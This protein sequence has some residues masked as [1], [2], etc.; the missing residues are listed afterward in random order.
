[1]NVRK[2]LECLSPRP[3]L[4]FVSKYRASPREAPFKYST[5]GWAAG[6]THIH[7]TK[8]ERPARD[9]HSSLLQNLSNYG[10]K[11]FYNNM[12]RMLQNIHQRLV[13]RLATARP[14]VQ[15]F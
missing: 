14:R 7:L 10:R 5:L 13:K 12:S 11:K 4:M 15:G 3:S 2:K 1:M 9:K 8:L 6:L